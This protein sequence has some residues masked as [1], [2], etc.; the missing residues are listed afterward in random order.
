[1]RPSWLNAKSSLVPG[2][3]WPHVNRWLKRM[4]Y[5]LVLRKFTYRV[6]SMVW[7]IGFST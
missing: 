6:S 3:W 1:L 5:R 7:A 4:G 2:E